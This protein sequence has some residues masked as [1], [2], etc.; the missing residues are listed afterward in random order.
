VLGV[1][2]MLMAGGV[3]AAAQA[4]PPDEV[5]VTAPAAATPIPASVAI[6][7]MGVTAWSDCPSGD[8]CIWSGTNATGSR[9]SWSNADSDWY[10]GTIQC[11][12]VDTQS[13]RSAYNHGTSSSYWGVWVHLEAN[14]NFVWS[15]LPQGY[16]WTDVTFGGRSHRWMTSSC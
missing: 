5:A 11:S 14:Y 1:I 13:V 16:V 10:S 12:W 15:C 7:D 9:C 2:S 3:T 8:F 4:T 6:D